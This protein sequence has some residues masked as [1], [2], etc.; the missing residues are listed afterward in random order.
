[1]V[2][3]KIR[4]NQFVDSTNGSLCTVS[5]GLAQGLSFVLEGIVR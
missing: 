5:R 3:A 1:M 2:M 4:D